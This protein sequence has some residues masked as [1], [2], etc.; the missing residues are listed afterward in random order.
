MNQFEPAVREIKWAA[1]VHLEE[2][3][4]AAYRETPAMRART[5]ATS[6]DFAEG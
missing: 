4:Q 2:G 6:A 1:Q 5:A 3:V